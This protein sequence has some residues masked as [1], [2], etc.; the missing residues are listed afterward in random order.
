MLIVLN[1]IK[2]NP[3]SCFTGLNVKSLGVCGTKCEAWIFYF[4][5]SR[6]EWKEIDVNYM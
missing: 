4:L 2:E 1:H 5:T 3:K 6:F